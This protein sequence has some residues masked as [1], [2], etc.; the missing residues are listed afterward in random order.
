MR[1][2]R[3]SHFCPEEEYGDED[4]REKN[5]NVRRY[6]ERVRRRQPLFGALRSLRGGAENDRLLPA[7]D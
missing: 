2:Y 4:L 5:V 7:V 6:A 1:A 3:P